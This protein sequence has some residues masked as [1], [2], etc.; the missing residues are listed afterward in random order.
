MIYLAFLPAIIIVAA[1]VSCLHQELTVDFIDLAH[2]E[3]LVWMVVVAWSL[4]GWLLEMRAGEAAAALFE[5]CE[6]GLA[7]DVRALEEHLYGL[8]APF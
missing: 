5:R 6:I 3:R 7:R 2:V 8:V 4:G 1:M